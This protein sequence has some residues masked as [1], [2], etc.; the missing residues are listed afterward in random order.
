MWRR[1]VLAAAA[2][3]V[4]LA[5][6][7]TLATASAQGAGFTVSGIAAE[8]TAETAIAARER[9]IAAGLRSA[10]LALLARQAPAE[11]ARLGAV[12][13]DELERLVESYEVENERLGAT[14]YAATLT[15]NFRPDRVRSLLAATPGR[16]PAARLEV[17]APLQGV[18]DWVELRRRLA[19]APAVGGY[20]LLSLS[21]R[22][23]RL[24]LSLPGGAAGAAALEQAGLR[25]AD[26]PTGPVLTLMP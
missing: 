24:A 3:A 12:S 11:E 26:G 8:A 13:A 9:A 7:G 6:P 1:T 10:W 21:R 20:E 18:N 19:N 22:E 25:L 2:A 16:A 17:A 5:R 14:R 23:A 4:A 15:V